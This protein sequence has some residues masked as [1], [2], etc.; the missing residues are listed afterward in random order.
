MSNSNSSSGSRGAIT[1]VAVRL[2]SEHGYTGTSMRDIAKA[3]GMLPGSLYAHIDSKETLLLE[4]VQAGIQQFLEIEQ[5]L[6]ASDLPPEGRLRLAIHAHIKL[7][8]D[9]PERTL[10]VFHQ[11]RFLGEPNRAR[12]VTMRR[13]YANAYMKIVKE[14]VACG[15]FSAELDTRI[16]VFGILG[17]LN[18][19]PE[20][21]SPKGKLD[22]DEIADKLAQ[23]LICGLRRG[24]SGSS[25]QETGKPTRRARVAGSRKR[26]P[27]AKV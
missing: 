4:I 18:W 19:T 25:A 5:L 6:D 23:A 7:V 8:A 14:G 13:R 26:T 10:I 27:T 24:G 15:D 22:A 20:W 16:A 11:W 9:N 21:Y 1:E 12:A 17:A 2:F 3:V